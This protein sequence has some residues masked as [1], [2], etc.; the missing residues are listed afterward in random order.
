[1]GN[2][3]Q[4]AIGLLLASKAELEASTLYA[5]WRRDNPGEA[6]LADAYWNLGGTPPTLRTAFGK[7]LIL[8]ARAYHLLASPM[9]YPLGGN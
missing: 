2:V 8:E 6:A 1:M 5:K 3:Y 7:H 4:D 9:P